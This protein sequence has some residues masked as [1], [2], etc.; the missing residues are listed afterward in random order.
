MTA[1]P[2]F[3]N[4]GALYPD[5]RRV[6][7]KSS[8]K[9]AVANGEEVHFDQTAMPQHGAIPGIASINEFL[10]ANEQRTSRGLDRLELSVVGPDPYRRRS[11]YA[12]VKYNKGKATVS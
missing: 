2:V 5:G 10:T 8:L 3:I 4:V 11:W 1:P 12:A 7:T 6:P 9:R